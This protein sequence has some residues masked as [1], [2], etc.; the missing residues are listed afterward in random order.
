[1]KAIHIVTALRFK[2]NPCAS[3]DN[4][5]QEKGLKSITNSYNGTLYI[6]DKASPMNLQPLILHS[7]T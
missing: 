4:P 5:S 1:M 6:G 2:F 3:I 7:I